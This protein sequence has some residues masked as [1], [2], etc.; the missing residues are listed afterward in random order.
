MAGDIALDDFM[1]SK[2]SAALQETEPADI[3]TVCS[4]WEELTPEQKARVEALKNSI[5]LTDSK[6]PIQY[7]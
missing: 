2:S 1:Q 5:D 6:T 7:G 4:Q 3:K